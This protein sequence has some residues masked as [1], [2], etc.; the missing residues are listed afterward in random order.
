VLHACLDAAEEGDAER[1]EVL[2]GTLQTSIEHM[3]ATLKRMPEWCD[4]YVYY[5]RVRPYIHGW[6]NHPNLPDGLIYEGVADYDGRP[7]QFRGETG[8]QSAIVPSL[9]AVLGIGHAEDILRTYLMEM[10]SYMSPD[11]RGFIASLETRGSVRDF[12]TRAAK[13][14]LL[15]IYDACIAGLEAFRSLHLEYAAS[16]VFRQAQTDDKNPHAIGTGGTPFM[17]YLKKHRDETAMHRLS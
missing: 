15:D 9:D 12:V 13:T 7:Q 5:H 11:Q 10:R 17:R 1:L 6:K 4:P 2:L 3:V 16:Y 14:A 8:A